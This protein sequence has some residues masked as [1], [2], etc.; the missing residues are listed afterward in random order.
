MVDFDISANPLAFILD[1]F[2]E[3]VFILPD[4]DSSEF[5]SDSS[6]F[7][8]D[9]PF[10]SDLKDYTAPIVVEDEDEDEDSNSK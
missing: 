1:F 8:F 2:T 4:F 5:A 3:Y 9:F 7:A 10:A 6:E